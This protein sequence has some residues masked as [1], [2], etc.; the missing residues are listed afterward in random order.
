MKIA[1]ILTGKANS[2]FKN[3]NI[4]KINKKFI[5]LYPAIEAKKSKKINKFF[6]SSDSPMILDQTKKFGYESIKRPKSL[7]RANSKHLDVLTHALKHMK[8]NKFYP[9]ILVVLLANAPIIK[10][11][12]INDCIEKLLKNPSATSIVPVE[13]NNDRH[14]L[15]AKRIKNNFLSEFYKSKDSISTNRQD[16]EPC[17]F[18]CHNFWIIRTKEILKNNGKPPWKFMGKKVLAYE[19]KNSIDIHN[20]IDLEIARLIININ[21]E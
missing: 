17:F 16:L 18:L 8:R 4:K 9:D 15:R 10:I 13:K 14:P 5:F 1:A 2:S 7:A 19:V 3:K 6:T 20:N 21:N 12:W 11:K